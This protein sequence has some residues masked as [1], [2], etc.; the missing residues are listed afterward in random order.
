MLRMLAVFEP[1]PSQC[2]VQVHYRLDTR[3]EINGAYLL[4][5]QPFVHRRVN[6]KGFLVWNSNVAVG[7]LV[8]QADLNDN[9]LHNKQTC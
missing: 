9:I 6:A 2:I 3:L 1:H 4:V 7:G 8:L 5:Q